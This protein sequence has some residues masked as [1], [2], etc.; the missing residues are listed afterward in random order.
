MDSDILLFL[1]RDLD[2]VLFEAERTVK[3]FGRSLK[4]VEHGSYKRSSPSLS[5]HL[6]F[7]LFNGINDLMK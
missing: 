5:C 4:M 2:S 1:N 7:T 6:E 3:P